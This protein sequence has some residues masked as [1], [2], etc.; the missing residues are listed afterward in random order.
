MA[1]VLVVGD[2]HFSDRSAKIMPYVTRGIT[3]SITKHAPDLVVFLGDTLDRFRM[4]DS[5]WHKLATKFL[6]ETSVQV[7][8]LVLI[9]NHDIVNKNDF[10]SDDHGFHALDYFSSISVADTQAVHIEI[11]GFKFL[12][13]PY[14]PN[15]RFMEGVNTYT[16]NLHDIT[17]IFG[18]QEF[19]G[20]NMN[21]YSSKHGDSWPTDYPVVI[22]GH[23]HS[24]QRHQINIMY[25]GS[26][27]QDKSDE[28]LDKSISLYTF[29]SDI[30]FP[31][32][33]RIYL[34]V[35][36]K[37]RL[38]ID[39]SEYKQLQV[40]PKHIYIIT[41]SDHESKLATWRTNEKTDI[42]IENG[43]KVNFKA[44]DLLSDEILQKF[45]TLPAIQ[46]MI[47]ETIKNRDNLLAI[48]SLIY[49]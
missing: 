30:Q 27:Y 28:P 10:M 18:H 5:V 36:K 43:G 11:K 4:I 21:G 25:P 38:K 16:G 31:V 32:E 7:P 9:G 35:P 23:I 24:H 14:C 8:I 49:A 34:K 3:K 26:P 46:D 22:S 44:I 45:E 41:V 13:V 47:F 6:I 12:G 40:N 20:C 2:L 19:R 15:G 42:I 29:Q 48:H 17:A 39:A 1:R 37:Y 33:T